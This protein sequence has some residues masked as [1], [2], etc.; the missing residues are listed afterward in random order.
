VGVFPPFTNPSAGSS[1]S[2]RARSGATALLSP[3]RAAA[4]P[5]SDPN[6]HLYSS[7]CTSAHTATNMPSL[8]RCTLV[9]VGNARSAAYCATA[10]D[11][12]T[13]KLPSLKTGIC[14]NICPG[15]DAGSFL[16]FGQSPIST[17]VSLNVIPPACKARRV[18]SPRPGP[19]KYTSSRSLAC[20]VAAGPAAS[21]SLDD[22]SAS[23]TAALASA[24]PPNPRAFRYACSGAA[25]ATRPTRAVSRGYA[26]RS[27]PSARRPGKGDVTTSKSARSPSVGVFPPFTNPSA[28]SSFS[29]RAR[30]GA[31]ALLSPARAAALPSSDPNRHLYS[32]PCTSA[33]TATNMPSLPRCTL[34]R[35]GNARSAAYCATACDCATTKLPSL[36]TGIC[37]NIC[38]GRDAGSFLIFGQ[39]PISTRV[40]LNSIPPA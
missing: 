15:R 37:P 3:A 7:P 34:V 13:T 28:G 1:F 10:C 16:I 33:H 19:A 23:T 31:T 39:S 29:T 20:S 17:R 12:A 38:P 35:V 22:F 26:A 6:R 11:C 9:R 30:S 24:A 18:S 21:A 25:S 4:L 8:P 2:T 36:K 14:P 32:S 5:S 27:T 40:S